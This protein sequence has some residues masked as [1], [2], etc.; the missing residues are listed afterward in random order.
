MRRT[1]ELAKDYAERHNVPKWYDRAEDLINDPEV[2]A[3]YVATPPF[4]HKKYTI[5]AAK[6]VCLFM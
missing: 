6:Q 2:N 3:V 1:G 4:T 5:M